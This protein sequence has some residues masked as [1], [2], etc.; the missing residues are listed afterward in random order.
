MF[1][2]IQKVSW[3]SRFERLLTERQFILHLLAE[4]I[5]QAFIL[6]IGLGFKDAQ[7]LSVFPLSP[8]E[9]IY[10][11]M[12]TSGAPAMGLGAEK[13][14]AGVMTRQPEEMKDGIL[15]REVALDMLVCTSPLAVPWT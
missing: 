11:I 14:Q 10:I 3:S 15:T 12:V 2:N 9:I 13:A 8:L 6:L 7:N 5:A 1:D 4:N